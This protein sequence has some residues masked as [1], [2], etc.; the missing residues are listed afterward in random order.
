MVT[1]NDSTPPPADLDLSDILETPEMGMGTFPR[2]YL[3]L[4]GEPLPGAPNVVNPA[5]PRRSVLIDAVL[6]LGTRAAVGPHPDPGTPEELT[7]NEK[8]L[9]NLWVLL[10]AQYK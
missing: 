2:G 5:F 7:A 8:R 9:F 4:C 6:G 1:V 3:N 10:G